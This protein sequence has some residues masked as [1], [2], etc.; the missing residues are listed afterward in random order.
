M[1]REIVLVGGET[2][3]TKKHARNHVNLEV[4]QQRN[5]LI[6]SPSTV[7]S[8]LYRFEISWR[9]GSVYYRS[10]SI[11]ACLLVWF[12]FVMFILFVRKSRRNE[13]DGYK[14]GKRY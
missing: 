2:N 14:A 10:V 6:L 9:R 7:F 11:L 12:G 4:S 13:S 3:K 5:F 8:R 1:A